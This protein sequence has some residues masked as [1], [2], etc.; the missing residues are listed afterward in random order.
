MATRPLG[1]IQLLSKAYFRKK[2]IAL[3]MATM[4]MRFSQRPPIKVS[5]SR[6]DEDFVFELWSG[7]AAKTLTCGEG[8]T[9]GGWGSCGRGGGS[10]GGLCRV[11]V[12]GGGGGGLG[13]D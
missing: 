2:V 12:A 6:L 3:M 4:P 7:G 13:T 9:S 5:K 8:K 1:P 11:V 10:G